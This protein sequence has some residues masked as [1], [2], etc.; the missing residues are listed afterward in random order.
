[1]A[2]TTTQTSIANR[3]LQ[4][5]GYQPITSLTQNDRGARAM[6]R[7]Y[8]TVLAEMLRANY[9]N[10]SIK[11]AILAAS[12]TPPIFGKANFFPLPSDYLDL[13]PPDQYTTY[14]FG[15]IPQRP[16]T[17]SGYDDWSIENADGVLS[18]A[19]NMPAPLYIRYVSSNT[20]ESMYDACFVEAFAASL[21]MATC[22]ELT[23]SNTKLANFEKMYEA[24]MELAKKRGAFES[25][26]T[27]PPVDT[28]ILARM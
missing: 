15:A 21:A 20:P 12:A 8:P 16:N 6:A 19:S 23:Q 27:A 3:A 28:W 9:W 5:V 7:A 22:E 4:L 13:A 2:S 11:R 18:I 14:S 10:F 25:K 17:G 24:Q 1:M 26:P